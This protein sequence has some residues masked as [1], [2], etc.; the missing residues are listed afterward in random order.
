ML[1]DR[2]LIGVVADVVE[3]LLDEPAA[4]RPSSDSR[5]SLD[6]GAALF[7]AQARDEEFSVVDDLCQ[8][9]ELRTV[10]EEVRAHGDHQ[11]DWHVLL[12]RGGE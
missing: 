10:A 9:G 3:E 12:L 1:Q 7:A 2:E 4:D 5:R 11:I 8:P 6:R